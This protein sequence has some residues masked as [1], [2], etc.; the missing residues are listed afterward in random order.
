MAAKDNGLANKVAEENL[1]LSAR[2]A[3]LEQQL[4]TREVALNTYIQKMEGT[5]LELV[6]KCTNAEMN[7]QLVLDQ[8]HK[9]N[10]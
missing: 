10:K 6:R 8:L 3:E 9:E 5:I 2:I 1:K 4:A 7:Y